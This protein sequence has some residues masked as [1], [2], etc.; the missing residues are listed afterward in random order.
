MTVLA[1]HPAVSRDPRFESRILLLLLWSVTVLTLCA[2][3]GTSSLSTDDAMRLVEVRDFI[4]G[5]NW[6]DLTQYRLNPPDGVVTHW[7]RLID[8]PLTLLIKANA[9]FLPAAVAERVAIIVWPTAL[10]LAF[11]A[12]V[13]RLGR[14]LAGDTAARVALIFAAMTEPVLQHFRPGALH[15]HNVQI[16]LIIWSLALFT[17]LPSRPRDAAVAGLLGALSVAIGQE[18]VP[19]VATLAVIVAL[20]WVVEGGPCGRATIAYALALAAGAITLAA[21]T[22]APASYFTVHCDA[23]SIAQAGALGLGGFGLAVLATLPQLNSIGRRLTAAAG[24][25]VML[26]AAIKF[27]APQC[28]GDPYA[29]LDPRLA[30]QWLASVAEA[31]DLFSMMRDLPQEIPAYF[32]IPSAALVLGTIRCLRETGQARWNW[33]SCTASQAAF[34]VVSIWQLRGTS[35]ANALGAALV[36]AA[37]LLMLPTLQGRASYF[38]LSRAALV[39]LLFLNP[40]ALLALGNGAAHAVAAPAVTTRRILNSGDPGTCQRASDYAPLAKLSRGRVLAFIDSGPFILMK[41]EHAVF[42]AP[43]HRNQAG[44]LAMRRTTP[45]SGWP[46]MTST[47]SRSARGR[48]SDTS[49]LPAR[50]AA[51]RRR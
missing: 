14:E 48:P 4:A 19:A 2:T 11:F 9:T 29:Q 38:G 18:M 40:V 50:P 5:Q 49:M 3:F 42:A 46:R 16:V 30:G 37:L 25:A 28:L 13:M 45:K 26:A 1:T 43:Y 10:L 24:L 27:E 23:I 32:G 41:S 21:A 22:V 17:R 20:R 7:S 44:N 31:R 15:H 12:G 39:V 8:L 51:W 35:G 6:F 34:L 33:I 47:M 36:P